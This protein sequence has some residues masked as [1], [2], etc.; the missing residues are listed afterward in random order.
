MKF[1]TV[2]I[3]SVLALA[4]GGATTSLVATP[5]APAAVG[6]LDVKSGPNDN[7][8]A[9]LKVQ[10]LAPATQLPARDNVYVAWVRP[11]GADQWQNVGQLQVGDDRSGSLQITVPYPEF[12]L[13]VSAESQGTTRDRGDYVVLQGHVNR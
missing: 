8:V 5:K 9:Q 13:S 11:T 2:I 1:R 4:C 12:D 10:H 7:T 6:K 3:S